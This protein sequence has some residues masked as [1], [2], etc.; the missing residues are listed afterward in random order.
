[1]VPALPRAVLDE[2][3]GMLKKPAVAPKTGAARASTAPRWRIT[4]AQPPEPVP[5]SRRRSS[6]NRSSCVTMVSF[7]APP[8]S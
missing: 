1:M 5:I 8:K 7:Y 2:S 6:P 3:G 4:T